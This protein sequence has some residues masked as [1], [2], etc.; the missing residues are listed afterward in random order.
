MNR[1]HLFLAPVLERELGDTFRAPQEPRII[2]KC[3]TSE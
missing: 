3:T 2:V 1:L